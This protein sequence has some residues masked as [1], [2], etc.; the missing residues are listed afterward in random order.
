M[1]IFAFLII[2]LMTSA[3]V[4]FVA[5]KPSVFQLTSGEYQPYTSETLHHYGIDNRIVMAAFKSVSVEVK[6]EF[7]PW[8]R[9]LKWAKRTNCNACFIIVNRSLKS[10]RNIC[11]ALSPPSTI[12]T[13]S[14]K[15]ATN[16]FKKDTA[17]GLHIT[18]GKNSKTQ[19]RTVLFRFI[20]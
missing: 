5:K 6:T 13:Q 16:C 20:E 3:T 11:I 19:K 10:I 4:T 14:Y 2:F 9:A 17:L 8:A 12:G 1:H 15:I 18:M 7:Y